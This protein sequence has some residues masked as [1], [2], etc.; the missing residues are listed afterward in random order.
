MARIVPRLDGTDVQALRR[1]SSL[2]MYAI[3]L[4]QESESQKKLYAS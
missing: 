4:L 3:I 2:F 1:E